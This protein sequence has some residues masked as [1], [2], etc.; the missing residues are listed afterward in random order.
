MAGMGA[1]KDSET[2]TATRRMSCLKCMV[3]LQNRILR[4]AGNI[5]TYFHTLLILDK[6]PTRIPIASLNL[7]CTSYMLSQRTPKQ[8]VYAALHR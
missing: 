3:S 5:P 8:Y 4:G 2:N 1:A 6:F 7:H